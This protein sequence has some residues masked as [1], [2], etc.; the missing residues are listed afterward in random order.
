MLPHAHEAVGNGGDA[1]LVSFP[2]LYRGCSKTSMHMYGGGNRKDLSTRHIMD[3]YARNRP[4]IL[5]NLSDSVGVVVTLSD[6]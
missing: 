1:D 4:P 2:L 3:V 6:P 5:Y